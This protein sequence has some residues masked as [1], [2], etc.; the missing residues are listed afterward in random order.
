MALDTTPNGTHF[1]W[2]GADIN[3]WNTAPFQLLRDGSLIATNV[4]INGVISNTRTVETW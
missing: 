2:A 3:S 1:M 4:S